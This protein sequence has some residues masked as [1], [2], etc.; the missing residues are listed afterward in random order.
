MDHPPFS[1]GRPSRRI[2]IVITG[3]GLLSFLLA[4]ALYDQAFPSA[5]I[6]LMLSRPD[7]TR[8][9][10]AVLHDLGYDPAGYTSAL[11]F[12]QD[13]LGSIYMQQTLGI[14]QTNEL[15]QRERLPIAMPGTPR[16]GSLRGGGFRLI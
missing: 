4:L 12:F 15:L 8:T 16:R 9:A 3:L 10:E 13:N 14:P 11:G 6:R 2:E 5:A 7:A 1:P